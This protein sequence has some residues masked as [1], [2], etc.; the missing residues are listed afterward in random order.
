[1]TKKEYIKYILKELKGVWE[2]SEP[3]LKVIDIVNDDEII[4]LFFIFL[5]R[6]IKKCKD[7]KAINILK[8]HRDKLKLYL[9]EEKK[10]ESN[11]RNELLELED[12]LEIL[13]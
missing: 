1:M 7:K 3:F 6:N 9:N 11:D 8:K 5:K 4:N 10:E 2:L 13:F 12:K